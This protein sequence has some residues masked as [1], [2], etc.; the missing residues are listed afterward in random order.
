MNLN[1]LPLP[2]NRFV[3]I[4]PTS[5]PVVPIHYSKCIP[6]AVRRSKSCSYIWSSPLFLGPLSSWDP[7]LPLDPLASSCPVF[8]ISLLVPYKS[9]V[10]VC[11]RNHCSSLTQIGEES[12]SHV[13]FVGTWSFGWRSACRT[14]CTMELGNK[15]WKWLIKSELMVIDRQLST[16]QAF[17]SS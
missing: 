14:W 17:V 2:L 11:R 16:T 13:M 3:P 10:H 6:P 7:S 12:R 15:N 9:C 5:Q 8:Q 4:V 1:R